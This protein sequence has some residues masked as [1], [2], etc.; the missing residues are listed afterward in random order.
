MAVIQSSW[1]RLTSNSA[2]RSWRLRVLVL[3]LVDA[4]GRLVWAQ[5][6]KNEESQGLAKRVSHAVE[7][8]ADRADAGRTRHLARGF[9][10]HRRPLNRKQPSIFACMEML[11]PSLH[12]ASP[13]REPY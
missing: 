6:A 5:H 2:A 4:K 11:N 1:S 7:L 8:A 10:M 3:E 13:S 9:H 12:D